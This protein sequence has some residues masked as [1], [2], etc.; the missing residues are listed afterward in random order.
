MPGLRILVVDD[1]FDTLQL[2]ETYLSL[3]GFSVTTTTNATDGLRFSTNGFD[4]IVTDLAMPGMDGAEFIRAMRTG[5]TEAPIPV[6]VVTGQAD[7]SREAELAAIG[8]CRLLRKPCDLQLLGQSLRSLISI[9]RHQC[10]VCPIRTTR[11]GA[12]VAGT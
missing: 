7:A 4:A 10:D 1:H 6:L 12:G 8:S 11:F 9:C 3:Q 2:Y 5:R